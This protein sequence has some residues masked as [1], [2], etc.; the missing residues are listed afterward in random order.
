MADQ[1]PSS[2]SEALPNS[3]AEATSSEGSEPHAKAA[4]IVGDSKPAGGE[5]PTDAV[6]VHQ[7]L[8][9]DHFLAVTIS[10]EVPPNL[11]HA[12]DQ[13]TTATDL[14]DVPVLDYHTP[15]SDV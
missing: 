2:T 15:S 11:D 9:G 13:L 12:L 5:L 7:P 14:F 10:T 8:D 6:E 1:T 4:W 3:P